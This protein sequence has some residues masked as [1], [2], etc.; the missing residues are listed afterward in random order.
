MNP[1]WLSSVSM[2]STYRPGDHLIAEAG[3]QPAGFALT[4]VGKGEAPVGSILAMGVLPEHRRRGVGRAL[5]DSA[6]DRLHHRDVEKVQ[7]GSGALQYFWPG[8]PLDL[9]GAWPFFRAM[10]WPEDEHSFDLARSLDDYR[11]PGWVWERLSGLDNEILQR[12]GCKTAFIGWTGLV[13]WYGKLGFRVW[14]EYG[15]SRKAVAV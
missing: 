9:P 10:G 14:Q 5:H 12:R 6:M 4:Q 7:L 8:V 11:T 2:A 15:M 1:A 13:D 3:G